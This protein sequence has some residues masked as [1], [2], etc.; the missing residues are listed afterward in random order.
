VAVYGQFLLTVDSHV[1]GRGHRQL[2]RP[3]AY[4]AV[5]PDVE[6]R[7]TSQADFPPHQGRDRGAL[8]GRVHRVGHI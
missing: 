7:P 1:G 3:V 6:D 2:S 4:R 5:F 8:D